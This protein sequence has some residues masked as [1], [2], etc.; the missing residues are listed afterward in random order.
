MSIPVAVDLPLSDQIAIELRD[1]ANTAVRARDLISTLELWAQKRVPPPDSEPAGRPRHAHSSIPSIEAEIPAM[2]ARR[3]EVV[4]AT[5]D[6]W[7]GLAITA[8]AVDA[9]VLFLAVIGMFA[10]GNA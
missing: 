2:E 9:L 10:G 3:T 7:K 4:H 1:A 5:R 8:G 6:D